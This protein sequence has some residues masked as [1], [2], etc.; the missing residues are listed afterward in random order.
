MQRV[1]VSYGSYLLT[2]QFRLIT[3]VIAMWPFECVASNTLHQSAVWGHTLLQSVQSESF[4]Y[5]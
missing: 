3:D 4:S 2:L 5:A 1:A